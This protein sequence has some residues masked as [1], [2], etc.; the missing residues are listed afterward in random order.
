MTPSCT[1]SVDDHKSLAVI[2]GSGFCFGDADEGT[3]AKES[4][5]AA[6]TF[7]DESLCFFLA[8]AAGFPGADRLG[9][10]YDARRARPGA[11]STPPETSVCVAID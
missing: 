2:F 11:R 9:G 10:M 7:D 5:P 8:G 4:N 6:A 1:N 3:S